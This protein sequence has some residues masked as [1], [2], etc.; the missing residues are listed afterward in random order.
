LFVSQLVKTGFAQRS[1]YTVNVAVNI[2]VVS[3][4]N[5]QFFRS[6]HTSR[7]SSSWRPNCWWC[8]SNHW[9]FPISGKTVI[10][11]V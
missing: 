10:F 6:R 9:W 5:I 3:V 7:S 8:A 11:H 4:T 2:S 1:R